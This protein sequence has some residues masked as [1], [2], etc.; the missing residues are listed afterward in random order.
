MP[1]VVQQ[2]LGVRRHLDLED[3]DLVVF[4]RQVMRG[5]GRDLDRG[6]LGAHAADRRQQRQTEQGQRSETDPPHHA[7]LD[8][9]R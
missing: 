2:S 1:V 8:L 7:L 4:E 9:G 5:L 3:A 6:S